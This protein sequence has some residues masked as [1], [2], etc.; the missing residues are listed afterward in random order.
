MKLTPTK[1][2]KTTT[3]YVVVSPTDAAMWAKCNK[4]TA[5][6]EAWAGIV[7]RAQS[8][9]R[10]KLPVEIRWWKSTDKPA[11]TGGGLIEV[12]ALRSATTAP[13]THRKV[14]VS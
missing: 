4:G 2:Q 3:P 6:G 8:A 9:A 13:T 11:D 5:R 14:V 1:K 10:R 12:V 7:L